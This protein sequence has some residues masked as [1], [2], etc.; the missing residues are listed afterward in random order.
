[1]LAL[2]LALTV[3]ACGGDDN[4]STGGGGDAGGD[5]A[6]IQEGG[7]A[8][9]N[10]PSFPDY[11][12]PAMSYTAAGWQAL[13][14]T[15]LGLVTYRREEGAAG[16]TL[17]PGLAE[18]LP[19]VSEDG[20]TY[21]FTL[22]EGLNYSDGSPIKAS[23]FEHSIKRMI[24]LE[25]GG[26]SF[27]TGTIAGADKYLESGAK[28]KGDISGITTDDAARTITI[29]LNGPNGQFP[30]ILSMPFASLVPSDT[31]FEVMTKN[32]PP[33]NGPFTI[34]E[35]QGSRKFVLE[36]NAKYN[37]IEG[38]P[39]PHLDK[40]TV[41][42]VKSNE[43]SIR[44]ILQNKADWMDDPSAG[45][46]IREFK[47]T[48]PERYQEN[49]TNS[50]YY[51]FLNHRVA[52]FDNAEV[53]KAVHYAIDKSA[54]ARLFGGQLQPGCNFLPPGMEG[55]EKIDPCP[56]GDPTQ[57]R[58]D[59]NLAK[60]RQIVKDEGVA[61]QKVTVWGNTEEQTKAVTEYLS[62]VLNEIGFKSE[63]QIVDGEVYFQ[64]IGAQKTKAQ[65][66]FTNWFQD[67]PHPG[68]FLFLVDPDTIQETNNQNFGNVDDPEIKKQLDE[69]DKQDL[70]EAASG[71]AALDRR[72]VENADVIPYGHR[73][74]PL[75]TS[76]R[77]AFDQVKF[78]PVIQAD[79]TSFALKK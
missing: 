26:A 73:K 15:Y 56:Y 14:P 31:P 68:N 49:V 2:M 71:Y 28:P 34:T 17:I 79:F 65:A 43:R 27:Y 32:P 45:D 44:D 21:S 24:A 74:L 60:A 11:L 63:P 3:A 78:H 50:T 30:F 6:G 10:Y 64:S 69:L 4:K 77:I 61:G 54:L 13:Q 42:T 67:F 22:R 57:K 25:S 29:K 36:K 38:I 5:A 58:S 66:G 59:E 76:D 37:D 35:V 52:P 41:Q 55:Y 39:A 46:A 19:E 12:D 48:A 18:A 16:A 40:I 23:D 51:F 9:F 47:Q 8:T 53:R 70:S 72:L 20:K 1:M 7:E 33:S 75:F 62:D